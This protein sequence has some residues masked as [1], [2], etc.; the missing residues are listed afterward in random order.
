MIEVYDNYLKMYRKRPKLYGK[1]NGWLDLENAAE[2]RARRWGKC[3]SILTG[4]TCSLNI[5]K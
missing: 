2:F 1:F 5:V 4:E 3:C